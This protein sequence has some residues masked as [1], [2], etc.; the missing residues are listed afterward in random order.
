MNLTVLVRNAITVRERK[1]LARLIVQ[2]RDSHNPAAAQ[3]AAAAS[4]LLSGVPGAA[5]TIVT[6]LAHQGTSLEQQ[7]AEIISKAL[8]D[9]A[10]A[11][12]SP[13][14]QTTVNNNHQDQ[15]HFSLNAPSFVLNLAGSTSSKHKKQKNKP[16]QTAAAHRRNT[17]LDHTAIHAL[18]VLC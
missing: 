18:V 8:A 15:S 6:S 5:A 17:H 16:N 7:A 9:T 2:L 11:A 3:F 1:Q 4:A 13:G 12:A 14:S 10:L